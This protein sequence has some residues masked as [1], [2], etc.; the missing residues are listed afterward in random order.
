MVKLLFLLIIFSQ[1]IIAQDIFFAI[2]NQNLNLVQKLIKENQSIVKQVNEEMESPLMIAFSVNSFEIANLLIEKGADIQHQTNNKTSIIHYVSDIKCFN[3]IKDKIDVKHLNNKGENLLHFVAK[4]KAPEFISFL[5]ESSF[6]DINSKDN[7]GNTPLINACNTNNTELA[8]ILIKQG[9]KLNFFNSQGMSPL[10]LAAINNNLDLIDFLIQSGAHIN[11]SK[12]NQNSELQ[13][14]ALFFA[15]KTN[16]DTETIEKLLRLQANPNVRNN[17]LTTPLMLAAINNNLKTT[18]VLIKYGARILPKDILNNTA[19]DI[20]TGEIKDLLQKGIEEEMQMEEAIKGGQIEFLSN[21]LKNIKTINPATGLFTAI[22]EN[23]TEAF[24]KIFVTSELKQTFAWYNSTLLMIAIEENRKEIIEIILDD[25]DININMINSF[26][27]TALKFAVRKQDYELVKKL[28]KKGAKPDLLEDPEWSALMPASLQG[29]LGIVKLLTENEPK[30]DINY[31]ISSESSSPM[32]VLSF[33]AESGDTNIVI[34]LLKKGAIMN[35]PDSTWTPLMS[36]CR[37]NDEEM[38]KFLI[39][40]GINTNAYVFPEGTAIKFAIQNNNI[41]L[42]NLLLNSGADV[43]SGNENY[44]SSLHIAV[45]N[46]NMEM[47]GLL[48]N[49]GAK[50]DA[51]MTALD[52]GLN[53]Y[54]NMTPLMLASAKNNIE[55]VRFL[56]EHKAELNTIDAF[57]KTALDLCEKEE[58]KQLLIKKGAKSG[59]EIEKN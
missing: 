4:Q 50:I 11:L 39:T 21:L 13:G 33:A 20:A 7:F 28:L 24:K 38:S 10:I 43:N 47:L 51:K 57:G 52:E 23:N 27:E 17:E 6:F 56:L 12:L 31:R 42:V 53:Q 5:L 29:N 25:S 19:L 32:N 55:M 15:V 44:W 18:E 46:E 37:K 54:Y 14:T 35:T 26:W 45:F 2:E 34:F 8:K 30:G 3:L 48:I 58:I 1:S 41:S 49:K 9:G 36:A 16:A 59:H 40:K 22:I